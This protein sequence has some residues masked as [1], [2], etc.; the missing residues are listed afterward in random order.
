MFFANA[1]GFH[2]G[3]N[4]Q[5]SA[6]GSPVHAVVIDMEGV[7]YSDTDAS[8]ALINLATQMKAGAYGSPLPTSTPTSAGCGNEA[9]WSTLSAPITSPTLCRLRRTTGSFPDHG[10]DLTDPLLDQFSRVCGD[11]TWLLPRLQGLKGRPANAD[12]GGSYS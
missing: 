10:P 3:I 7:M 2:D 9:G 12:Q 11:G 5:V 8:D 6:F 4:E 1:K